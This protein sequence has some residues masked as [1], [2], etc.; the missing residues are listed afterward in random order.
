V[1]PPAY[2]PLNVKMNKEGYQPLEEIIK[3]GM[4]ALNPHEF[5]LTAT[6]TG[7]LVLDVRTQGEYVKGHIPRSIFIGLNGSF[8]PWVGD[9]IKDVEQEILLVA[10]EDQ[11]KEA[12]TRLSRVGFDNVIGYLNGGYEVWA[13]E[14]RTIDTVRTEQADIIVSAQQE[15]KTIVDV[16][17]PSEYEAEHIEGA[18]NA[19]LRDINDH[20]SNIP[21]YETFYVHCVSGYRSVIAASILKS[22]GYHNL[23]NI[24]GGIQA[25]K[26]TQTAITQFVCPTTLS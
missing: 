25:I 11:I 2:F 19:S 3:R 17:K 26:K 22:R 9:L 4:Q 16:R 8:A 14:N 21:K 18:I 10:N 12:I 13:A 1:T 6:A 5:E 20:L 7:A 23:I 15:G 24:D